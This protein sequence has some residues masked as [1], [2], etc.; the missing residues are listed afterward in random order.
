MMHIA[1]RID[2]VIATSNNH[3]ASVQKNVVKTIFPRLAVV[4]NE[5]IVYYDCRCDRDNGR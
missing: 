4:D 2:A 5:Q 1:D 3:F